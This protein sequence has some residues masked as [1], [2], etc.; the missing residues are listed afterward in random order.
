MESGEVVRRRK[1]KLRKKRSDAAHTPEHVE[2]ALMVFVKG[3]WSGWRRR[4][5]R[6][7]RCAAGWW[8]WSGS[9]GGAR[10]AA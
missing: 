7:R 1:R 3:I 8:R 4:V 10:S 5:A 2:S 9:Y 6:S